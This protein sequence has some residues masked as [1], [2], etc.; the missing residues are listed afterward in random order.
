VKAVKFGV[1]YS[2]DV[3]RYDK[4]GR[5]KDAMPCVICQEVIKLFGVSKVTYTVG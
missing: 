1:P 5:P 2:I 4:K 3:E